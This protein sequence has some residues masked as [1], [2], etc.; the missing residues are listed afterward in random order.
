MDTMPDLGD[1]PKRND[2]PFN[3]SRARVCSLK[4]IIRCLF[5]K[6][7]NFAGNCDT[8]QIKSNYRY[9]ERCKISNEIEFHVV[10]LHYT[11]IFVKK[12]ENCSDILKQKKHKMKHKN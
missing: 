8:E 3:V 2:V 6:V 10:I 7:R 5:S 4:E 1:I 12:M 9:R 11:Y